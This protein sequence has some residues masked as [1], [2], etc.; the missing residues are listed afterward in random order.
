MFELLLF[1]R[2]DLSFSRIQIGVGWGLAVDKQTFVGAMQDVK[3][4]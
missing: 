3:G 4:F 1:V 2:R